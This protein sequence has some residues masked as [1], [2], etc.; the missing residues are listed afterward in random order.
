ML[1]TLFVIKVLRVFFYRDIVFTNGIIT[2]KDILLDV[3]SS[4]LLFYSLNMILE[5][6]IDKTFLTYFIVDTFAFVCFILGYIHYVKRENEQLN[7]EAFQEDMKAQKELKILETK[8]TLG[9]I[10]I[11]LKPNI[12]KI[13]YVDINVVQIICLLPYFVVMYEI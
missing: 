5:R 10:R 4:A 8:G 12:P 13:Q 9:N 1:Y 11:D 6:K 3:L 2:I 7:I